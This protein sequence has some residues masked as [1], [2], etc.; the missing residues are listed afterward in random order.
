MA[1]NS[2]SVQEQL[3]FH[4]QKNGVQLN[5]T[6]SKGNNELEDFL[7]LISLAQADIKGEIIKR[8][9]KTKGK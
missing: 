5:F 8:R 7:E 1:S 3:V 2:N 9:V 6:L 4:Y